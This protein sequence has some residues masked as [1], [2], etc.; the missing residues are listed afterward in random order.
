MEKNIREDL[1]KE[2]LSAVS[3]KTIQTSLSI[4]DSENSQKFKKYSGGLDKILQSFDNLHEWAD[5]IS[6]LSKLLKTLH[7][8]PTFAIVPYQDLVACRLAQCLNPNL[9]SGVHQKTLEVYS[10]IFSL[11]GK[12]GLSESLPL[13]NSGLA[14]VL[15]FASTKI[16]PYFLGLIE[17]FYLPLGPSLRPCAKSLIMS[18]LPGLEEDSGEYFDETF[19]VLD[20]VRQKLEDDAFF[21]QCLWLCIITS[22]QQRQG[23]LKYL[24]KCFP[25]LKDNSNDI[26]PIIHPDSGL[27]IRAF[28]S[29]LNDEQLLIRRG[30]LELLVQ[31]VPLSSVIFQENIVSIDAELL[32]MSA[33][34][35]VMGKEISLNRRVWSWLMGSDF[36]QNP[37]EDS[38]FKNYS[39]KYVVGCI[40]NCL[41][42]S[43]NDPVK[44]QEIF[45]ILLSLMERSIIGSIIA[46]EVFLPA[47]RTI[48]MFSG[49][50]N[51]DLYN[52]V[53]FSARA[54]FDA[55]D[56]KLIWS[57]LLFLLDK[58]DVDVFDFSDYDFALYIIL[59]FNIRE[60]DMTFFHIP[61]VLYVN[62]LNISN[63]SRNLAIEKTLLL[64]I[65]KLISFVPNNELSNVLFGEYSYE[66]RI[67]LKNNIKKYYQDLLGDE[68]NTYL[69]KEMVMEFIFCLL[70]ENIELYLD[71]S[72]YLFEMLW[73]TYE[74]I[75]KALR[76]SKT[77]KKMLLDDVVSVLSSKDLTFDHVYYI[78][79]IIVELLK[80]T[81]I[82]IDDINNNDIL[83]PLV[84]Y[85]WD[86]FSI[87]N[88]KYHI[89][90]SLL[91][92]TLH[93]MLNGSFIETIIVYA[94]NI[95]EIPYVACLKFT[96]LWKYSVKVDE[97]LFAHVLAR[98]SLIMIGFLHSDD[99]HTKLLVKA[100]IE[101]LNTSFIRLLDIVLIKLLSL[102]FIC[103]PK[104][105]VAQELEISLLQFKETDDISMFVYYISVCVEIIES[106][107]IDLLEHAF[108]ELLNVDTNK[109]NLLSKCEV[110][111]MFPESD[112]HNLRSM[113][114][115]LHFLASK[116]LFYI[117]SKCNLFDHELIEVLLKRLI[118]K[119]FIC[120]N[121]FDKYILDILYII[122]KRN[123]NQYEI[124]YKD[125]FFNGVHS[126][127]IDE[128]LGNNSEK[129]VFRNVLLMLVKLFITRLSTTQIPSNIEILIDFYKRCLGLFT[130]EMFQI[131]IPFIE[132]L[133]NQVNFIIVGLET[134]FSDLKMEGLPPYEIILYCFEG[135]KYTITWAFENHDD[136]L[137]NSSR[138]SSENVGFFGNVMSGVF[139]LEAPSSVNFSKDNRNSIILCFRDIVKLAFYVWSWIECNMIVSI[140]KLETYKF[141]NMRLKTASRQLIYAL[142]DIKPI[143]TLESLV[144]SVNKTDMKIKEHVFYF[145]SK[146]DDSRKQ[147]IIPFLIDS[148]NFRINS[149]SVVEKHKSNIIISVTPNSIISFL[150]NFVEFS[151]TDLLKQ[152]WPVCLAF[153]RDAVNSPQQYQII[154]TYILHFAT[155]LIK[156]LSEVNINNE[157]REK[158]EMIDIYLRILSFF[159]SKSL[160]FCDSSSVFNKDINSQ[161]S[162]NNNEEKMKFFDSNDKSSKNNESF[163]SSAF[164]NRELNS[165]LLKY[166]IPSLSKIITDNEKIVH[167]CSIIM[168]NVIGSEHRNSQLSRKYSE[169]NLILLAKLVELSGSSKFW[170]KEVID[171]FNDSS[172]FTI[173]F[174]EA[175]L[176]MPII[177]QL[178]NNDKDRSLEIFSK[179]SFYSSS[180]IFVFRESEVVSRKY[181]LKRLIFIIISSGKDKYADKIKDIENVIF[182]YIKGPLRKMLRKEIFLLIRALII[183]MSS[184]H[185]TSLW[186]I[187]LSELQ[188]SFVDL[189]EKD[190]PW[191]QELLD[192][193]HDAC[194]LL[195]VILVIEPEE[196]LV[197]KWVFITDTIDSVYSSDKSKS[198]A[199]MDKLFHKIFTFLHKSLRTSESPQLSQAFINIDALN[200]RSPMLISK[201]I[202]D[203]SDIK[204][205]LSRISEIN[206][207]N[208]YNI[209]SPDIKA[210]EMGLLRDLF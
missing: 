95:R 132:T 27:F 108:T 32:V 6:F 187:I 188:Y 73:L 45:N 208:V 53:L 64:V 145:L 15:M 71:D 111:H 120:E 70:I 11:I 67:F 130:N 173:P 101:T 56:S 204:P 153:F 121:I 174:N 157:K 134:G 181:Q 186:A 91:L 3:P 200:K 139:S 202:E 9:P 8:Y 12:N 44:L 155:S 124:D 161:L 147:E 75:P 158:K 162:T 105:E 203:V 65:H 74:F 163:L 24:F 89:D 55:V 198:V 19:N 106:G 113:V 59:N 183:Y 52:D 207:E 195:D 170:K 197:H 146:F 92:W 51:D 137:K 191:N 28:S 2:G 49:F 40:K 69:S 68:S 189:L 47:L 22:P 142:Y 94:M 122:L 123:I 4:K 154:D 77:Q 179:F 23:A 178:Y 166:V 96:I 196:F 112:F 104:S 125:F 184:I 151:K 119:G 126:L 149:T 10:Y 110:L 141:I 26:L 83:I 138:K 18:L 168:T 62:I 206:Y 48:Y 46:P 167:A 38:Y 114:I 133:C 72:F 103:S 131:F 180:S 109:S 60:G 57:K 102:G 14:P 100:W 79:K 171:I 176:W 140:R 84:L 63:K 61:M 118:V 152:S 5:Y 17:T 148:I 97:S 78:V 50:N 136:K 80:R 150:I 30:F 13:W 177:K 205:F 117:V 34:K 66:D 201:T 33:I 199:L 90:A 43:K 7:S 88:S 194:K 35:V 115:N 93:K 99:I 21:W 85:I 86:C 144:N 156:K 172:F 116:L 182:E 135:L 159:T 175:V 25:V 76:C 20:S 160:K 169:D 128:S 209:C 185:L 165:V 193:L 36:E 16:K 1:Q 31:N 37:V 87:E 39:M 127:S 54:F 107:G 192:S 29:G 210:C 164:S 143:E 81:W 42:I 190:L 41:D 98:P 82:N 58:L 129:K